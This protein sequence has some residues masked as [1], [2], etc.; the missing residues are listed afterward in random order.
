[1][2]SLLFP[3][4]IRSKKEAAAEADNNIMIIRIRRQVTSPGGGTAPR[5]PDQP[6][7]KT[8]GVQE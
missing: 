1:M 5:E 7:S 6:E 4:I 2:L 8:Y 3:E